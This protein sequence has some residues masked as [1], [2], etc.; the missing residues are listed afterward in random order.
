M[1]QHLDG[2]LA[3][4][5]HLCGFGGA[6]F[7]ENPQPNHLTGITGFRFEEG[8]QPEQLFLNEIDTI[9]LHHGLYSTKIPYTVLDVIGISLTQRIR[10]TLSEF[11]FASFE[12]NA[13]GFVA[14]RSL[15]EAKKRRK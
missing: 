2:G 13:Q 14:M 4:A 9:D 11:G 6:E 7:G 12:E 15:D 8:I 3:F 5:H 1:Q 10:T